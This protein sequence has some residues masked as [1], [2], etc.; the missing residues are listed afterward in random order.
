MY[1]VWDVFHS[2]LLLGR[3][4]VFVLPSSYKKI[5]KSSAVTEMGDRGQINMDRKEGAAV[6][7]SPGSWVPV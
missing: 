2:L 5:K 4:F 3:T 1:H 6:P 7:L